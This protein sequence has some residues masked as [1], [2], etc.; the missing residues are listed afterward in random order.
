MR[1]RICLLLLLLCG[2]ALRAARL[3]VVQVEGKSLRDNPLG[4]PPDRPVALFSPDDS[5]PETNLP[6]VIYLPG[7]GSSSQ[8][9]IAEGSAGWLGRATDAL[10]A[11]KHPVRIAVVD[12][13]SRYGGSQFL[14]SPATGLY[15][16]YVSHDILE[17]LQSRFPGTKTCLIAGHSSGAYGALM[18][19]MSHHDLFSAVVALSPDSD[20]ETTHKPLV[21]RPP[22]LLSPLTNSPPPWRQP[23]TPA[24]LMTASLAWSWG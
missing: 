15:A 20:F 21:Q 16:D 5:R 2:P 3:E 23:A 11:G 7:W 18:L 14:N 13:R 24:S 6:L 10:A 22:S 12:G 9:V 8:Q 17:A 4:D 1:L 19:A